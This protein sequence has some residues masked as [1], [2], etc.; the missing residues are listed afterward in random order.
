MHMVARDIFQHILQIAILSLAFVGSTVR[1][2]RAQADAAVT[3]QAQ[4]VIEFMRE[5]KHAYERVD[6]SAWGMH[7]AEQC[8]FIQ[9]GGRVLGK[10]QFIAEMVPF[11]GYTFSAVV[12][13]VQAAE[14][15]DTIILTYREK[16]IRDY[17]GQRSENTYID[18]ETYARL[19]GEWQ[20][21]VFTENS[22]PVEPPTVR[23]NPQIY[24]KYVG[25]Y[26]VNPKATFTVTREGSRLLGQYAGEAK[27]ELLPA[28]R[29]NFFSR[30][31]DAVYVFV[32]DGSGRVVGHIYRADGAEIKYKKR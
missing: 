13:D 11:V 22:L 8:S 14:F 24:D 16:E 31:D 7:V 30:G 5:R 19:K 6:A 26:E 10:A 23:L 15:G 25:T 29:S 27:F 3:P 4:Q 17:G 32:W 9:A 2:G 20:L 21:I 18:T 1:P 28:S 12:S